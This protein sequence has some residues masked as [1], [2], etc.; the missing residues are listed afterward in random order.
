MNTHQFGGA[1]TE[2]KLSSLRKYLSA[3]TTIFTAN[4]WARRYATTYVDA[5]AGTGY[6][7]ETQ[8]PQ[9]G[10]SLL[11]FEDAPFY[12]EETLTFQQGSAPIALETRPP[13]DNYLFIE[14]NKAHADEL[15]SLCEPYRSEGRR[16]TV[17]PG[18]ANVQLQ[19]WCRE[20]DWESNRAVVF[21]DPYG[22]EV[23]WNTIEALAL[24]EG[25]DVMILFPLGQAVNR[26]LTKQAIPEG[27]IAERLTRTFGTADWRKEFY[28]TVTQVS[29]FG[30]EEVTKKIATFDGISNFFLAR[31]DKVFAKV[32]SEPL[33]LYNSRN[34]PIYSLC[35][36]AANK[37]G[38]PTAVKIAQDI[39]SKQR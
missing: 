6:R 22:M 39:F 37:Q 15:E 38:A 29:M 8:G 19:R 3:Y 27:A 31:L 5:F 36:A 13:F 14:S 33:Y 12:E 21:L 32:A 24:T 11:F 9:R 1:W 10:P 23:D 18:D 2:S 35:F 20:T 4:P 28:R 16:I 25:V 7:S 30:E 34:V 26:L 17:V